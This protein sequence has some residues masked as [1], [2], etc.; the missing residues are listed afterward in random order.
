MRRSTTFFLGI[1]ALGALAALAAEPVRIDFARMA[2][3][4]PPAGFS[5]GRTGTGEPGAWVVRDGALAQT[6]TD[7]TDYRFPVA[8]YEGGAWKDVAVSVRFEAVS[9]DVDRAG[10]L[11]LRAKD[12]RSYALVRANALEGNVRLYTVVGGFRK[13]VAGK[14]VTVTAGEW[15]TLR[16]EAAGERYAVDLDGARVIEATDATFAEAG[17]VGVWT[18]ADSVTLFKDLVIEP[19]D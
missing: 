6:S 13:E 14:N 9:G 3:G 19:R 18:K 15:H 5:F 10:G 1:V 17:K 2:E 8:L 7:A 4:E 16:V 12:A 11:V